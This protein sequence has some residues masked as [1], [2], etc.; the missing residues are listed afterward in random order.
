M[1]PLH[2]HGWFSATLTVLTAASFAPQISRIWSRSSSTDISIV[3]LL[4]TLLCT[5]EHFT[6]FFFLLVNDDPAEASYF[7]HNPPTAGDWL[8]STHVTVVWICFFALF[9]S[10][11]CQIPPKRYCTIILSGTTYALFLLIAVIPQVMDATSD[12]FGRES[13]DSFRPL[14][15]ALFGVANIWLHLVTVM[16]FIL[17]VPLQVYK[18]L[19]ARDGGVSFGGLALQG[20]MFGVTGLSWIGRIAFDGF[21]PEEEGVLAWYALLGWPVVDYLVFAMVQGVVLG[22]RVYCRRRAARVRVVK[23]GERGDSE[24]LLGDIS[25]MNGED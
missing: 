6:F 16:L 14:I 23:E 4:A 24:L 3:H 19:Y 15:L 1:D 17:S 2:I 20:I 22:V 13:D 18:V 10:T 21:G 5:T 12:T 11:L 25:A 8:N 7:I 9:I